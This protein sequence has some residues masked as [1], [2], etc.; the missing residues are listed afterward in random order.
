MSVLSIV[1]LGRQLMKQEQ[2][3][4]TFGLEMSQ[5]N[6]ISRLGYGKTTRDLDLK[7]RL[8]NDYEGNNS[9]YDQ[10]PNL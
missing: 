5:S 3:T 8:S 2:D 7:S 4:P 6:P 1:V 9:F 10:F